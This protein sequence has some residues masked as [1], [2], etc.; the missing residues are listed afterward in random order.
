MALPL[1]V[2]MTEKMGWGLRCG[3]DVPIGAFVLS[4]IGEVTTERLAEQSDSNQYQYDLSHFVQQ[5]KVGASLGLSGMQ[6][7]QALCPI[8]YTV[9]GASS[10]AMAR[11]RP[12][13]AGLPRTVLR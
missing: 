11:I 12:L 4:Y 5:H 1:E 6:L 7:L 3:V 9:D 10:M 8:D 2:F 13:L